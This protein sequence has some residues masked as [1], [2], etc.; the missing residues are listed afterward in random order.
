VRPPTSG[1]RPPT[2]DEIV[3]AAVN[4]PIRLD[5]RMIAGL[6]PLTRI[7]ALALA[8]DSPLPDPAVN[9]A[10]FLHLQLQG[11]R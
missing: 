9:A 8:G 3:A 11:P 5:Y 2:R 6:D 7:V 10:R 4:T 1:E